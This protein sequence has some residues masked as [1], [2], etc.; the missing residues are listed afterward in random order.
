MESTGKRGKAKAS[1]WHKAIFDQGWSLSA[2]GTVFNQDKDGMIPSILTTWFNERKE[3]KKKMWEASN[4]GDEVLREYYDRM[5][6]IKKIQ[7]NAM[8]GACGNRFFKFFDMRLAESV[9]L[10]GREI[11]YHMARKIAE[12]LSGSYDI[13]ADCIIYGDTDSVY[14]KT[15]KDNLEDA[16]AVSN[17]V[18]EVV[19]DSYPEFMA[20]TFGC[21][22]EHSQIMGAEQ[23]IVSDRGI[24]IGKKYYMLH[25]VSNDGEPVDKMK[26]M[27]VPIK[28]TTL[29]KEIKNKL[30][31]FIERLLKGEDWDI[32]GPDVVALKDE[33]KTTSD[34]EKLGLPKGINKLESYT[35]RL[36]AKEDGLR[37]PGHVAASILWNKCLQTYKDTE[38]PRI[39]SGAKISVYYITR[40]IDRF[41]SI[42]IPKDIEILPDWFNEHFIP[43][44]DRDAQIE[45]LVDKPMEIMISAAGIKVPTKKKLLFEEG[46][47]G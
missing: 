27:G 45:R 36:N 29:P 13:E 41:K 39:T 16:L 12:E 9:T 20:N 34:V 3:Y 11:L 14:F 18:A 15:Y 24:Y 33:L 21:N 7:L 23:E 44:I 6:Y 10:T 2:L 37:L 8:Y 32:I 43:I 46:L 25:L 38:S 19:N 1:Y 47:F 22:E 4:A 31:S 26:Y 35:K 28:K 17:H 42:A 40:P 30:S 5:Q